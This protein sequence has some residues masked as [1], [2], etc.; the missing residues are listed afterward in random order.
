MTPLES[1]NKY[2][3]LVHSLPLLRQ[4]HKAKGDWILALLALGAFAYVLYWLTQHSFTQEPHHYLTAVVI[5]LW[6]ASLPFVFF[7]RF[8][9][10]RR[11]SH[12]IL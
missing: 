12:G 2:I 6:L 1:A 11:N 9:T 4:R 3:M 10:E 5:A 8:L 7:Y